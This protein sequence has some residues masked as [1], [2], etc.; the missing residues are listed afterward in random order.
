MTAP[1]MGV[2]LRAAR[3]DGT[4][5]TFTADRA[6]CVT[7]VSHESC[8]WY[9]SFRPSVAKPTRHGVVLYG[10]GKNALHRGERVTAVDVGRSGRV[11]RPSGSNE[12]IPTGLLLLAGLALLIPL[13]RR[14]I[15]TP[16]SRSRAPHR[17]A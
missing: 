17:T 14:L 16:R 12:W 2:A 3:A 15:E 13:A 8:S 10:A 5:G 1:N 6:S 4:P 9:G 7:H 11:Y